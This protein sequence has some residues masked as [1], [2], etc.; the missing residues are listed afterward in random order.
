MTGTGTP[1]SE[2]AVFRTFVSRTVG[3]FP[4]TYGW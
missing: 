3:E 1:L 4:L 2:T